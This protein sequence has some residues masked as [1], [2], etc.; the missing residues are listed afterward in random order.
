MIITIDGTSGSGKSTAASLLARRLGAAHLDTGAMYRALTLKAL[1]T[2]ADLEDPA[3]LAALAESTEIGLAGEP[4]ALRVSMDGRDVTREIREN[5]I[6]VNSHYLARTSEVRRVLVR[7]QREFAARAGSIVTEGRDQGTVVFPDAD[8]KF[9]L[10][11]QS[12]VRARRRQLELEQRGEYKSFR[13]VLAE[14][15]ERDRRDSTRQADPLKPAEG[16]VHVDTSDLE[17][18][19]MVDVL[20]AEVRRRVPPGKAASGDKEAT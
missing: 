9:F 1:Q 4:G 10:D 5:R 2:H 16:A 14:V 8:V 18:E 7:K 6:S 11:A 15:V 19:E 13:E 12:E 3:A 20:A 17:I